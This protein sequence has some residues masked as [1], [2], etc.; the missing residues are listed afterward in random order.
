MCFQPMSPGGDNAYA[1]YVEDKIL[2]GIDM[3]KYQ[4]WMNTTQWATRRQDA[5]NSI[6]CCL[7]RVRSHPMPETSPCPSSP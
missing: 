1:D 2:A 5:S 4:I 7:Q 3:P 6:E